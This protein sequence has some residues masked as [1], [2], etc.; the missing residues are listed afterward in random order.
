MKS[1]VNV[2]L[3]VALLVPALGAGPGCGK[4]GGRGSGASDKVTWPA[5]PSDGAPVVVQ[6]VKMRKD[7]PL[8]GQFRVFNFSTQPVKRVDLTLHYLDGSGKEL[9]HFPWT[10]MG[11]PL[12]G[13]KQHRAFKGGAF[14]PK[15]TKRIKVVLERVLLEDGTRWEKMK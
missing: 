10:Q 13:V 6:F 7:R 15:G 14:I 12:V 8:R 11:R 4:K 3:A 2:G 9:K 1:S 5:K